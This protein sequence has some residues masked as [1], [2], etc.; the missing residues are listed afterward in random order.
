MSELFDPVRKKWVENTPEEII[1][2]Q[3]IQKMIGELGYPISFLAVEKELSKL[4]HLQL[5]SKREMPKR[6]VDIL[7]FS[8]EIHSEFSLFPLLMIEC[9]VALLTPKFVQQVVGYNTFVGAPF[10]ALANKQGVITGSFD[11]ER[12]TYHFKKGLPYYSLLQPYTISEK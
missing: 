12:G 2:Q 8:K 1:R 6:R 7:V 9:K 4:P 11:K 5:V 3:L 10:I